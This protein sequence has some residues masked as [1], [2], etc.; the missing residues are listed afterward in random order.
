M[1][2]YYNSKN[3]FLKEI[4]VGYKKGFSCL[5]TLIIVSTCAN[6][7]CNNYDMSNVM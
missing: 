3:I 4:K 1:Y 6:M 5:G 2:K 7:F